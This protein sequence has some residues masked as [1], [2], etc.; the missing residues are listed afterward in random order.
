MLKNQFHPDSAVCPVLCEDVE[1]WGEFD[2]REP[3]PVSAGGA[4][5]GEY[6]CP[7]HV[8]LGSSLTLSVASFV[9]VLTSNGGF[10]CKG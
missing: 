1:G 2:G 7:L 10:G 4:V 8:P 6:S 5:P 9:I 3:E